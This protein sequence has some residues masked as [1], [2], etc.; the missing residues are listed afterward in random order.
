MIRQGWDLGPCA[1]R[2]PQASASALAGILV[3]LASGCAAGRP[4]IVDILF[5]DPPGR[6]S[7]R[8]EAPSARSQTA[9]SLPRRAPPPA[10]RWSGS[11][12][13]PFAARLC[14][15]CHV[16]EGTDPAVDASRA[17]LRV[18]PQELCLG[19]HGGGLLIRDVR[20]QDVL[21]HG[22]VAAGLCLSCHLPHNSREPHL[23]RAPATDV[24]LGC[25]EPARLLPTHPETRESVCTSCHEPHAP[26]F[27]PAS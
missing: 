17:R 1:S 14:Q 16:D 18:A 3:L 5:D 23:L 7:G 15:A 12:H 2:W 27:Q 8:E 13:G 11:M 26:R 9:R 24:C 10:P 25:H 4:R 6:E 19:C 21:L 22:P 20:G